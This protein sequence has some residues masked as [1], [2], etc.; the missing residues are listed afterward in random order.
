VQLTVKIF[1]VLPIIGAQECSALP[2]LHLDLFS[3]S[4]RERNL[5]VNSVILLLVGGF[6]SRDRWFDPLLR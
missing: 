4:S 5:A 6:Q 1:A 3:L 2:R